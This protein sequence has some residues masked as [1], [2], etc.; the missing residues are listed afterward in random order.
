LGALVLE[1]VKHVGGHCLAH[2]N[3]FGIPAFGHDPERDV[4]SAD[5]SDE[6][7]VVAD[8]KRLET[9]IRHQLRRGLQRIAGCHDLNVRGHHFADF[10]S[11]CL[12]SPPA[13]LDCERQT[14]R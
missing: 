14:L 13:Q 12:P 4:A 11:A 1:T 5:R 9:K 10:H 2:G 6:A 7:V 8:R 3:L